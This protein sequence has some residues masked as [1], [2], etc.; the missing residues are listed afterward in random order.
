LR[1]RGRR[2]DGRRDDR[3]GVHRRHHRHVPSVAILF[4]YSLN[5]F[6]PAKVMVDAVTLRTTSS[7]HRSVLSRDP[8]PTIRVAALCTAICVGTGLPC[9]LPCAHAI[10]FQEPAADGGDPAAFCR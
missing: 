6:T 1:A 9:L 4:R 2:R 5:Q 8:V 7:F 10:A 3:T